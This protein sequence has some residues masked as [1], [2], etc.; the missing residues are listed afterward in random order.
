MIKKLKKN[1]KKLV[2]LTEFY[3]IKKKNKITTTLVTLLLKMVVVDKVVVLEDLV[4]QIS[5]IYLKISLVILEVEE[6]L[7]V[8]EVQITEV[9]I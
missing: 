7:E 3:Q 4:A 1:L 5:Q 6:D 2:K 9:Q 8:E